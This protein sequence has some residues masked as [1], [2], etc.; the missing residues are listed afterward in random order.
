MHYDLHRCCKS[1][2]YIYNNRQ[3]VIPVVA[4]S[5]QDNAKLLPQLKS[6]FK[7]ISWNIYLAKAELVA[8]N[9][10]LN[11]LIGPRFQGVNRLFVLAFEDDLQR[12]S[13]K[14]YYLPN[15]EM[16]DYNVLIDV[17]NFF[18]QAIKNDN[19]TYENIRKVATG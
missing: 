11:H 8:Q 6:G 7:K 2:S 18:D 17:K 13:I 1:S 10:N 16:K 5:T 9:A 4:L 3:I 15:V 19:V 12:T 14:K